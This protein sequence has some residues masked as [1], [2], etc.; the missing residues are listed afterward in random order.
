MMI[1]VERY[2][3]MVWENE[4]FEAQRKANCMCLCCAK[5]K[6][7]Q[8]GHCPV[9]SKFYEVCKDHGCAFILTRCESWEPKEGSEV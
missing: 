1:Q 3:K 2:G 4:V 5:M 6:P 8:L 7:G 9:A